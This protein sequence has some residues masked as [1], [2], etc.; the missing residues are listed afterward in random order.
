MQRSKAGS[1]PISK[2][3]TEYKQTVEKPGA[4]IQPFS[5]IG[6]FVIQGY[7]KWKAL[8]WFWVG[9]ALAARLA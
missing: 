9:Q 4:I 3:A 5:I 6:N 2:H 7:E 1:P 8:R